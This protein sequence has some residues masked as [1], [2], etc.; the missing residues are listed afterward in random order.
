[1][2]TNRYCFL[3]A[4]ALFGVGAVLSLFTGRNALWG[5][6]RMLLIGSAAGALT[7]YIGHLLGTTL[8]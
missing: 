3:T 1:M 7:Y 8:A 4:L 6:T 5:G 2:H